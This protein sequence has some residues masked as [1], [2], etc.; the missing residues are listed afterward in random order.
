MGSTAS[1][2]AIVVAAQAGTELAAHRSRPVTMEMLAWADH[3][4]TMT[5]SH[6]QALAGVPS[7]QMV[8][9]RLLSMAGE[10]VSDP[11]GGPLADYQACAEQIM[12]CLRQRLPELLES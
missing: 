7:A 9:P 8:R 10:D 11:I 6:W 3:V 1:P 12:A 5:S 4:F 2:E